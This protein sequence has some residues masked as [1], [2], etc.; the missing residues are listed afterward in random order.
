MWN[1]YI[2]EV[3][4]DAHQN[5]KDDYRI[6]NSKTIKGTSFEYQTKITWKTPDNNN[7]L[8][9]DVVV[10]LKFEQF[11]EISLFDFDEL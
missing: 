1:Y 2:D 11:L 8:N 7:R 9:A 3:N 6:N 4:D 5:N 10:P